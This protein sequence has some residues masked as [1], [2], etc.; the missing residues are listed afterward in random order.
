MR[1]KEFHILPLEQCTNTHKQ[2]VQSVGDCGCGIHCV[3]FYFRIN[4][5]YCLRSHR[6]WNSLCVTEFVVLMWNVLRYCRTPFL[7]GVAESGKRNYFLK[8][9]IEHG[10]N[11]PHAMAWYS[12]VWENPLTSQSL[13]K[14]EL[15]FCW[16]CNLQYSFCCFIAVHCSFIF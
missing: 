12:L 1:R 9:F 4:P 11:Y 10:L 8:T 15:C 14:H 3:S 5:E 7:T 13:G 16:E 2:A 6:W